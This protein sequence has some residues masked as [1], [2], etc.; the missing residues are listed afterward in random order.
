MSSL[1]EIPTDIF[2][3]NQSPIHYIDAHAISIVSVVRVSAT[4]IRINWN[5]SNNALWESEEEELVIKIFCGKSSSIQEC[6]TAEL[7][8]QV[9]VS[10]EQ[11]INH[12]L[13]L[14]QL[15]P[16]SG[17]CVRIELGNY[18]S[19]Q[20]FIESELERLLFH[21]IYHWLH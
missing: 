18:S 14:Q 7:C 6:Q 12:T 5:T 9:P 16:L 3:L 17:Y 11:V 8:G 15:D 20:T 13:L 4:D 1:R 2:H 19:N 21:I 10:P